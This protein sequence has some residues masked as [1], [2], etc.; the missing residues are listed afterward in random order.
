MIAPIWLP[1]PP[2]M[3]MNSSRK[4]FSIPNT[5]GLMTLSIYA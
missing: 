2:T 5:G 1:L 3:T 4:M